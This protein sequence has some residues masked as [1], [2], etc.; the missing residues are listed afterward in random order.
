MAAE[1][2]IELEPE[3]ASEA[4]VTVRALPR[5]GLVAIL[6][7]TLG[8]VLSIDAVVRGFFGTAKG[9]LAWIPYLGSVAEEAIGKV[10]QK[11]ISE[12]S[13]LEQDI[14]SALGHNIHRLESLVTQFLRN[15]EYM[16]VATIIIGGLLAGAT[17]TYVIGPL[18]KFVYGTIHKI[19]EEIR[20][21]EREL[22]RNGATV[23]KIVQHNIFP[24]IRGAEVSVQKILEHFIRPIRETAHEAEKIAVRTEKELKPLRRAVSK[25]GFLLALAGAIGQIS[26]DAIKCTELGNLFK[27]RGGCSL[28]KDLGSLLGLFDIFLFANACAILEFL[29]PFVSDVAAPIVVALTD[30]GAGLCKGGVGAPGLLQGQKPDIPGVYTGTPGL[31]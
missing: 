8:I 6:A 27:N 4:E 2:L 30:V 20:R 28:W 31:P 19:E 15:L 11:I 24:R 16:A 3:L 29:S 26:V 10:E 7:V 14:D 1:P 25:T 23:V 9:S 13:G 12:L 22:L 18:K 21:I 17:A 5:V